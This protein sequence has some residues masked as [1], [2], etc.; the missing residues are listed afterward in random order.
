MHARVASRTV[1]S[2][3]ETRGVARRRIAMNTEFR[4]LRIALVT[5]D[6]AKQMRRKRIRIRRLF[7][8]TSPRQIRHVHSASLFFF[9]LLS[10]SSSHI[11]QTAPVLSLFEHRDEV[12]S[13]NQ[14]PEGTER[15]NKRLPLSFHKFALKFDEIPDFCAA[16]VRVHRLFWLCHFATP[17]CV[18]IRG[19][20]AFSG[21]HIAEPNNTIVCVV[22]AYTAQHALASQN[23]PT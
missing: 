21:N 11:F 1:H 16:D 3:T 20:R 10:L 18:R 8:S 13:H 7:I 5:V 22:R 2:F 9:S 4:P 6:S 14:L 17:F 23:R 15:S 19:T 12:Y